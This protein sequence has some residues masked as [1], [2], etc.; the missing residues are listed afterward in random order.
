MVNWIL[1][2]DN[3]SPCM[4]KSWFFSFCL[5]SFFS[6]QVVSVEI[7]LDVDCVLCVYP[8]CFCLCFPNQVVSVDAFVQSTVRN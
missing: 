7:T 1:L 3:H 5:C 8:I 2:L 4:V 6:S